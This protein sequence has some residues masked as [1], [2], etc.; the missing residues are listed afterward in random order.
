MTLAAFNRKDAP[1]LVQFLK[2][3][4][5]GTLATGVQIGVF[6]LL[7]THVWPAALDR[8]VTDELRRDGAVY[9]NVAAF[10]ISNTF[11]YISNALWVF[12]GGRHRRF[13]EF[14]LFN[15]VS[16]I[17]FGAGLVA[18]PQLI[19]WFGVSTHLAQASFVATSAAVNFFIRKFFIFRK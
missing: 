17:S 5:C 15:L 10:P 1:V 6:Y 3:S 14:L 4:I 12:T 18:G 19:K 9:A 11:A 16:A 8:A 7:A 2:Y 13:K